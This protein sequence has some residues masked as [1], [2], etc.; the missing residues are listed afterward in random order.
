MTPE[1][2][3]FTLHSTLEREGPGDDESLAWALGV[4]QVPPSGRVL[5][6]GC[7]PGADVAGLLA[8]VPDGQVVAMDLH[9]PYIDELVARLGVD[10]RLRAVPG[11]MRAP[12]GMFDLIWC[13]GAI[14]N[15]GIAEALSAWRSH[16]KPGGRVAFSDLG[17]R[18]DN[19]PLEAREF[20]TRY[21]AMT[22]RAGI[23][24]QVE[25]A[26]WRVLADRWLP[27]AGWSAYYE[28]LAARLAHLRAEAEPTLAGILDEEAREIDIWRRHGSSYGY[29]QVVAEPLA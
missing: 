13:A 9:Q 20:W 10:A 19:P 23:L 17:W 4:A 2:A 5:D 1:D 7:G 14:Y 25:A 21:P 29:L 16:L 6:A 3:F 26:G 18:I 8:A 11:D 27:E 22:D 12:E 28:P 15:A 24:A